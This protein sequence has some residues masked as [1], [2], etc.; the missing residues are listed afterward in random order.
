MSQKFNY[1]LYIATDT[2]EEINDVLENGLQNSHKIKKVFNEGI[3]ADKAKS[4]I[5]VDESLGII[6][7]THV[8]YPD[9]MPCAMFVVKVPKTADM[10]NRTEFPAS[11]VDGV[12]VFQ[13]I[14]KTAKSFKNENYVDVSKKN[15]GNGKNK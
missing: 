9:N 7:A 5:K 14:G 6:G 11:I 4:V 13:G 8:Y 15:D 10:E 2:C 12:I 1:Y 3:P